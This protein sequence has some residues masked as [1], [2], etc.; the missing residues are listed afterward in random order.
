MTDTPKPVPLPAGGR[1][2]RRSFLIG[3][4][5]VLAGGAAAR[6]LSGSV[7]TADVFIAK[8]TSYGPGLE[9]VLRNALTE[10]GMGPALVKGRRVLLKPNL[11]EPSVDSPHINTHPAMVRAAAE[12][13]RRWDAERVIIAEGQGHCRDTYL[14]L[15]Q[16]GLGP[17]LKEG[18]LDFVDLNH[19]EITAVPNGLKRTGLPELVLPKTLL[20]ADLVVSMPKLKTHHWAVVT[21]SM[22]NLFG[23]MPGIYYGWPKNVLHM[24]GIE[25]SILDINSTVRPQLAIVDGIIGMEGDG[26]IMGSPR[27]SGVVVVG[28]NLPA[29]DA[30]CTRLMGLNPERIRY[31]AAAAERLGPIDERH[32][33]QRGEP[34][35]PLVQK[36]RLLDHPSFDDLR[37]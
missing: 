34:I 17:M 14:V 12:V 32:I 20:A 37:G 15:E 26:P 29:V 1:F 5:A 30:T 21:L 33:H 25:N 24:H 36:Y 35:A 23:I 27:T 22:K 9:D 16:S 31:L 2:P 8:A 10:L 7:P 18:G 28:H 6:W 3:A 11:V 4:G 19:D 13:F